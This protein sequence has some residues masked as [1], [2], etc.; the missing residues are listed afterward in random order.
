MFLLKSRPRFSLLQLCSVPGLCGLLLACGCGG[1]GQLVVNTFERAPVNWMELSADGTR[2]PAKL[3][4]ASHYLGI[5]GSRVILAPDG[6]EDF[7][8]VVDLAVAGGAPKGFAGV[9]L[10]RAGDEHFYC[11]ALRP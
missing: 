8:G 6:F 9:F 1:K 3:R 5:S 2:T 7:H 10:K 11:F 4:V